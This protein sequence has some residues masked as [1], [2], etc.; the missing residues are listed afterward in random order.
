[1]VR[2]LEASNSGEPISP[3]GP[4]RAEGGS[5]EWSPEVGAVGK[6]E[7]PLIGGRAFD[8]GMQALG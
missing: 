4:E 6:G 3:P 7:G 5:S 8:G 1:M 2:H